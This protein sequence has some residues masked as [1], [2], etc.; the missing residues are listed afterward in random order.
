MPSLLVV[1]HIDDYTFVVE[2]Q[3]VG[4]YGVPRLVFIDGVLL[5]FLCGMLI[6]FGLLAP[7]LIHPAFLAI[8]QD[9]SAGGFTMVDE[10]CLF[11]NDP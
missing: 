4:A 11:G 9:Q 10:S 7:H 3:G 2:N 1:K 5:L 6:S 8:W